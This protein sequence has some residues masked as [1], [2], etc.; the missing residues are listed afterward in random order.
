MRC[1]EDYSNCT[2]LSYV[3]HTYMGDV[4]EYYQIVL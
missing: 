1:N 3:L 4:S 2:A